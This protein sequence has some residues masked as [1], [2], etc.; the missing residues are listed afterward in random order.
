M[1]EN[2]LQTLEEQGRKYTIYDRDGKTAYLNRWYVSFPDSLQR[3][4]QD[5]P[6][7]MF[8]HQFMRSD[9]DVFHT[10]PWEWFHS[11]ILEGG[12]WEHTPW[13][14]TW[15]GPGSQ[16]FVDCRQMKEFEGVMLPANLH[17]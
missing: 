17:W 8:I 9:D 14:K 6:F 2:L 12:Y 10:H 13:A 5:I 3:E 16:R 4:R 15:Y 1:F 11:T 7:N